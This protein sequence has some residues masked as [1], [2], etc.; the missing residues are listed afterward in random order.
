MLVEYYDSSATTYH[1]LFHETITL[2]HS[3]IFDVVSEITLEA[4][5][6]LV[7]TT[8]LSNNITCIATIRE[9][10]DPARNT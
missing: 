1:T 8:A 3:V 5:D 4:G 6:A 7:L 9:Y 10:F 2:K